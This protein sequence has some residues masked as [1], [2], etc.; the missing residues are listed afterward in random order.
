MHIIDIK[1]FHRAGPEYD[2]YLTPPGCSQKYL[3][4]YS[5]IKG[6]ALINGHKVKITGVDMPLGGQRFFF[7]CPH[8]RDRKQKLVLTNNGLS[9]KKC[10][11]IVP[12]SLNRS[13]NDCNYYWDLAETVARTLDPTFSIYPALGHTRFPDKPKGMHWETYSKKYLKYKAY[14]QKGDQAWMSAVSSMR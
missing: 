5:E 7:I 4:S 11:G 1:V 2:A 9:C 10:L 13:K 6:E 14:K 3:V 8:C 12:R